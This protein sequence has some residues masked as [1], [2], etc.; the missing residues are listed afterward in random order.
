MIEKG[1]VVKEDGKIYTVVSVVNFKDNLY[2]YLI[3][4]EDYSDII[5]RRIDNGVLIPIMNSNDL[6]ELIRLFGKN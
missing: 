6:E 2:V 1:S 5:I 3:N 4:K